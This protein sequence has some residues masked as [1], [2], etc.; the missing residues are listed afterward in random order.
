[1]GIEVRKIN[2]FFGR[3]K[4]VRRAGAG[5]EITSFSIVRKSVLRD[6]FCQLSFSIVRA[7]SVVFNGQATRAIRVVEDETRGTGRDGEAILDR[8]RTTNEIPCPR[9]PSRFF[10]FSFFGATGYFRGVNRFRAFRN[11]MGREGFLKK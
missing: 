8:I 9:S 4:F 6:L 5:Q 10:R 11:V 3:A 1:M 2:T 7:S